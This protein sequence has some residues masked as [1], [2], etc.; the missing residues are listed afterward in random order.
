MV[1]EL[2]KKN[3]AELPGIAKEIIPMVSTSMT[4]DEIMAFLPMMKNDINMQQT[5]I[6]GNY[7]GAYDATIDGAYFMVYDIDSAAKHIYDFIYN[8]I[9]PNTPPAEEDAE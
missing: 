6:P 8:D 2:K 4:Y 1:D 7:D 3:I 5:M 9:D